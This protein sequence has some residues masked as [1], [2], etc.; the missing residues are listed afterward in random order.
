MDETTWSKLTRSA[1]LPTPPRVAL[2]VLRMAGRDDVGVGEVADL[3]RKDVA[4]STRLLK[5][6]NRAY[7]G[8][9]RQVASVRQAAALLG[10]RAL[11]L[12]ALRFTVLTEED[13]DKVGGVD[14][15][16]HWRRSLACGAFAG[17]LAERLAFEP[18]DEAYVA[19]LLSHV[20]VLTL[21]R[22]LGVRYAP[23]QAEAATQGVPLFQVEASRL[24]VTH[25]EVGGWLLGKWHLPDRVCGAI[26]RHHERFEQT[27]ANNATERL[28]R[29]LHAADLAAGG[30][31]DEN[32]PVCIG[33]LQRF[34]QQHLG[35]DEAT[36][37]ECLSETEREIEETRWLLDIGPIRHPGCGDLLRKAAEYRAQIK[38]AEPS[39]AMA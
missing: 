21:A 22:C 5:T 9:R 4:I 17:R 25:A 24:G 16:A 15:G 1:K 29:I 32:T 35:L 2:E 8:M 31:E 39:G 13:A 3:I 27:A 18:V 10:L 26:S 34:A 30:M 14:F 28:A 6:V 7:Y 20:G 12:V 38:A 33:M 36:V 19:G 11:K 37:A 23:V